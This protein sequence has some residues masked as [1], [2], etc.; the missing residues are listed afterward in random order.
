MVGPVA[1]SAA[2]G[3]TLLWSVLVLVAA[4]TLAAASRT[5]F[6]DRS[7]A[8]LQERDVI[9]IGYA[10]EAPYAMVEADGSV[11][12][13]SPETARR[14]AARLGIASVEWV[15]V[16]FGRLIPSLLER[17][18]DAIAAGLFITP[19][20]ER[21]VRFS[22]PTVRVLP[23]MLVLR[24][25]PK[26][27][28]SS[29]DALERADVQIAVL[30]GAVEQA[31]L[32]AAGLPAQRTIVVPDAQTGRSALARGAADALLLSLPTLRWM[33][34]TES[35]TFEALADAP[36]DG[37]GGGD[38]VGFA[39]RPDEVA[40]LRA[41]NAAQVELVATDEYRQLVRRF[42]FAAADVVAAAPAA[43]IGR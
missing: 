6:G 4:L 8:H 21:L 2:A 41:W 9:R 3:R 30:E 38:V 24:G 16:P 19:A 42:G 15:Q 22:A 26:R 13:E 12:G 11:T 5:L 28:S 1:M 7:L 29:R 35:G 36:A 25:N 18:F 32:R 31:R 37:A 43:G 27:L 23:G 14:I 40:L 39:F 33:A 10:V 17:R 20:R 34:S